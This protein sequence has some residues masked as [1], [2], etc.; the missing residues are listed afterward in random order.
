MYWW[1]AHI[2]CILLIFLFLYLFS[3]T[4]T[5]SFVWSKVR[6]WAL[7]RLKVWGWLWRILISVHIWHIHAISTWKLNQLS[8]DYL[9]PNRRVVMHTFSCVIRNLFYILYYAG[10]IFWEEAE[11]WRS[12]IVTSHLGEFD[13]HIS[14]TIKLAIE[15]I[16]SLKYTQTMQFTH[17]SVIVFMLPHIHTNFMNVIKHHAW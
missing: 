6:K 9:Y 15:C 4:W 13:A 5:I 10:I 12:T 11:H 7:Q 1:H 2:L 17:P 3:K 14:L 8:D 16:Y